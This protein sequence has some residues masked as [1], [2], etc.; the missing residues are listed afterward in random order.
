MLKRRSP[1]TG[2]DACA[3]GSAQM[4]LHVE[5][6]GPRLHA[7]SA[8]QVILLLYLSSALEAVNSVEPE[9][10]KMAIGSNAW[11]AQLVR[12]QVSYFRMT[13]FDG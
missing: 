12:A 9:H 5:G 2:P 1:F 11:M 13:V 8:V 10:R 7:L 4:P 3:L 6:L